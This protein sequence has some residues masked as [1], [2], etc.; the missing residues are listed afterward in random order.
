M[1]RVGYR[2]CLR[3]ELRPPRSACT[4]GYPNP[5]PNAGP[6]TNSNHPYPNL[7]RYVGLRGGQW[8][9]ALALSLDQ[10]FGDGAF[11]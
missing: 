3:V 4:S 9:L 1:V 5:H 8:R 2:V 6:D 10:D 11:D 7:T